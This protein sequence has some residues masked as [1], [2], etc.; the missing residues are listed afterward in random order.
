MPSAFSWPVFVPSALTG[1][2]AGELCV[3]PHEMK[4]IWAA[5]LTC[6][7]AYPLVVLFSG[8]AGAVGGAIMVAMFTVTACLI[9]IP[10]LAW[11]RT[12]QWLKWW[13]FAL[14]GGVIGIVAALPFLASGSLLGYLAI[15]S[16]FGALGAAHAVAF[17]VL[18]IFKNKHLHHADQHG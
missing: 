12:R 10:V 15:A 13:Q 3:R 7:F 4:R 9:G 6:A 16:G 1:S 17:W 11:F 8:A 18:A 5:F 2:G 14:G